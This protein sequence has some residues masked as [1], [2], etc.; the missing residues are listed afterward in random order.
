MIRCECIIEKFYLQ[1]FDE[2]KNIKRVRKDEKGVLFYGDTFECTE[3][4]ARYLTGE[5]EKGKV[6]A[7]VIEVKPSKK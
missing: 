6:V 5:N 4:M 7:K 3:K 1:A 2:L